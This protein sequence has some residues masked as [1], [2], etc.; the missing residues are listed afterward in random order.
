MQETGD[1]KEYLDKKEKSNC[2][3]IPYGVIVRHIVVKLRGITAVKHST[4]SITLLA[5]TV[6]QTNH[7]G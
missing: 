1:F 4:W 7:T 5:K 6:L 3:I 2:H